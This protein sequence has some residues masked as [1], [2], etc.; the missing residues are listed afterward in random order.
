MPASEFFG[1]QE[2]FSIFPF[3]EERADARFAMVAAVIANV[4]G[5]SLKR[6]MKE[7]D[8]MPHYI[9]EQNKIV[10]E[11]SLEQQRLEFAA[12]KAQ[13]QAAQGKIQ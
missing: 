3:S 7:S 11:K 8:F 9:Q 2:Y 12:F 13:L 1:W 4:S 10:V 6:A 5:K